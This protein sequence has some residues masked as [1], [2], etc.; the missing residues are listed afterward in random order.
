MQSIG[1]KLSEARQRQ[2]LLIREAAES[3][4]VRGDY[5]EAMENNKFDLIPLAE[6][7]RRGFLKIYAKFL[8][9]D[10]D[11]IL[12][13]F[14]LLSPAFSPLPTSR[15]LQRDALK[16]TDTASGGS[17][18]TGPVFTTGGLAPDVDFTESTENRDAHPLP[19]LW[20]WGGIA[21]ALALVIVLAVAVLSDSTADT[22]PPPR[23]ERSIA[24]ASLRYPI[25]VH[26]FAMKRTS[27]KVQ[28]GYGKRTQK[29]I[30]QN[31]DLNPSQ[32][33]GYEI[34]VNQGPL[35]ISSP[36]IAEVQVRMPNG[37]TLGA[38]PGS[39]NSLAF[40][41]DDNFLLK[42]NR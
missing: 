14:S 40:T 37:Q 13:E 41:I 16:G 21:I 19:K 32:R 27:V 11:K 28:E 5:L 42:R 1:E 24:S 10:P 12:G 17:T 23:P 22:S 34:V 39:R 6:V 35:W 25:K 26:L 20:I 33:G 18:S 38:P 8:H 36:D 30:Y 15:R 31:K 3:T 2:G 29:L 4:K 9:L 7:Y